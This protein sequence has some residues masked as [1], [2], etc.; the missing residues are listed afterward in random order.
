MNVCSPFPVVF[1]M[2]FCQPETIRFPSLHL[3]PWGYRTYVLEP[4]CEKKPVETIWSGCRTGCD[5]SDLFPLE[6]VEGHPRAANK[7]SVVSVPFV[8]AIWEF[9][10]APL[11][12][13]RSPSWQLHT[14]QVGTGT[15]RR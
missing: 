6:C 7:K 12:A 13:G 3:C 10:E 4:L 8:N 15:V 1:L 14:K 9:M 5:L 2:V 11:C